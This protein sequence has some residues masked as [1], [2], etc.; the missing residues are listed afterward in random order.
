LPKDTIIDGRDI[1]SLL[2]QA[3]P[4]ADA[5]FFYYRGDKLFACRLGPWKAHFITQAGYGQDGPEMHDPPELYHLGLDPGE[6]RNVAADHADVIERIQ[7]AVKEHAAKVVPG[8]AQL[9]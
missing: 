3:K 4:Q 5:P 2:F 1:S 8:K 7:E 9:D 6:K